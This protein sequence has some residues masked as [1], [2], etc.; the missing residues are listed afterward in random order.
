MKDTPLSVYHKHSK[1]ED[2]LILTH[3]GSR[4]QCPNAARLSNALGRGAS[5]RGRL[6]SRPVLHELDVYS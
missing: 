6:A 3:H 4:S 2:G 1:S 5:A